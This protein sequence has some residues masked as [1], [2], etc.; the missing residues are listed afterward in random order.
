VPFDPDMGADQARQYAGKYASKA[1]QHYFVE[2]EKDSVKFFLKA[3]TVG[4]C[5]AYN[6]LMGFRVVRSTRP[7]KFLHTQFLPLSNGRTERSAEHQLFCPAYPDKA[8]YLNLTQKYFYRSERLRHLR[9]EQF[10]RYFAEVGTDD[11]I[12]EDDTPGL[13]GEDYQAPETRHHRHF[14]A[15]VDAMAPGTKLQSHVH[16]LHCAA[17]SCVCGLKNVRRR[18]DARLGVARCATFELMGDQREKFY[19]QRLLLTLPWYRVDGGSP[20]STAAGG[21][22][23]PGA[24]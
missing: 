5:M 14:D 3:R 13:T 16:A 12:A 24:L 21:D 23:P 1:E 10:H 11:N 8:C 7:V 6:R 9:L 19:E 22:A 2:T 17:G 20:S 4:L 15:Q 18:G